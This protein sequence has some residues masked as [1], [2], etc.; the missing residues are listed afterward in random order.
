MG[1][2]HKF[3]GNAGTFDWERQKTVSY[4][5]AE[6]AKG[7]SMKWIIGPFEHTPYFAMRYIEIEPG[8]WS[9]LDQ[10]EHDH[11]VFVLRGQGKVRHGDV[12]TD[13]T[14]GDA[15]YIPPNEVHQ[16]INTGN[17]PFGFLC[18]IPRKRLLRQLKALGVTPE[19]GARDTTSL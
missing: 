9:S 2:I 17:E 14:Y 18:V 1:S 12:E 5:K 6:G 15:V 19:G 4:G 11:G 13:I 3:I 7:A 10:H 8:G 16:F